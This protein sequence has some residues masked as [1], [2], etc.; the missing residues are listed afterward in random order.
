MLDEH[1][2]RSLFYYPDINRFTDENGSVIHD[3]HRLVS[4]GQ[5]RLFMEFKSIYMVPD[6][7]HSFLVELIYPD[8]QIEDQYNYGYR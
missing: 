6:V 4:P 1:D 7:T 3:I 8:E 2:V 5:L